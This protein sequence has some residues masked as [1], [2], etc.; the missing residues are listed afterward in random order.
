MGDRSRLHVGVSQ[1]ERILGVKPAISK[2]L[3]AIWLLKPASAE[4]LAR[5]V[6]TLLDVLIR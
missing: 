2:G 6:S 4:V 1:L 5:L 3:R